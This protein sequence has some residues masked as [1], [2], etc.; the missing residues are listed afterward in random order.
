MGRN[1]YSLVEVAVALGYRIRPDRHRHAPDRAA[2]QGATGIEAQT[3]MIYTELLQA[4]AQGPVPKEEPP[5]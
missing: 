5:G 3:R 1:G 2:D 4:R